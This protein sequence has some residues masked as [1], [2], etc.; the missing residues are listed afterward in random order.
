MDWLILQLSSWAKSK[1]LSHEIKR[2]INR[3]I[4]QPSLQVFCPVVEDNYGKQDSPY[5]EY[6]FIEYDPNIDYYPLESAEEFVTF[7]KDPG[8]SQPQLLSDEHVVQIKTQIDAATRLYPEDVV[9]VME[10]P[11]EKSYG[12]VNSCEDGEVALTVQMGNELVN[13]SIPVRHVRKSIRRTKVRKRQLTQQEYIPIPPVPAS[14]SPTLSNLV[15]PTTNILPAQTSGSVG[16]KI[17]KIVR[18]GLKNTRVIIDGQ[19]LL[20]SNDD[21][22][23]LQD[24]ISLEAVVDES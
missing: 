7:L 23:K 9:K 19:S 20:I 24:S 3:R 11:M 1:L 13:I 5:G 14:P 17:T 6:V 8:T 22:K 10:G 2:A 12:V 4:R 21:L 16:Q 18:R 15:C